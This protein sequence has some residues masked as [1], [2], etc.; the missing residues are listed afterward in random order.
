MTSTEVSHRAIPLTPVSPSG[1]RESSGD[2]MSVWAGHRLPGTAAVAVRRHMALVGCKWDPQVEDAATTAEF[3]VLMRHSEW[4]RLSADA[5]RLAVETASLEA[6]VRYRPELWRQLGV[7]RSLRRS[8]ARTGTDSPEMARVFRFDL[9]PTAEGWKLSE[10]NADVPGGFAEGSELPAIMSREFGLPT[11]GDPGGAYARALH[12]GMS[13]AG[14]VALLAATGFM[15]DMQVVSYLARR[16][17]AI[18]REAVVATLG[19]L[20]WGDDAYAR[21]RT[22]ERE[23]LLAGVVRFY[24]AEWIA[25]RRGVGALFVGGRT[26]VASPAGATLSE[27]K[28]LPLLFEQLG[29]DVPTWRRL[30]PETR[31]PADAPYRHDD[32]W[33]VK[34]AYSNTGDSVSHVGMTDRRRWRKTRLDVLLHPRAWVAQRRFVPLPIQTP[35]GLRYPCVGVYVVN[36]KAAGAYVRLAPTAVVDFRSSDAALLIVPDGASHETDGLGVGEEE[37]S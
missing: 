6:A 19:Q 21:L 22:S 14:P 33:L 31:R 7:P 1:D 23:T 8:L 26:P 28:R 24:Q 35:D 16:L 9:H 17:E 11:A 32:T 34:A 5:E 20:V 4:S 15:E 36:G 18:G 25:R 37:R 27:S 3:P 2:R 29:V 13:T 30:L 12:E 10:V